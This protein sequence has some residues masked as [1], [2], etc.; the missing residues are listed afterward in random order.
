MCLDYETAP[1]QNQKQNPQKNKAPTT[2]N[3]NDSGCILSQANPG[4][5][6]VLGKSQPHKRVREGMGGRLGAEC[7][8]APKTDVW[9]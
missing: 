4:E 5:T 6:R 8:R 3:R 1:N 9:V 7:L 2:A